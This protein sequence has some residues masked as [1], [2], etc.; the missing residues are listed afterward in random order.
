[1]AA[2]GSPKEDQGTPEGTKGSPNGPQAERKDDPRE[3]KGTPKLLQKEAWGTFGEAL[4]TPGE[5]LGRLAASGP[6]TIEGHPFFHLKNRPDLG[7]P[8][9]QNFDHFRYEFPYRFLSS[10]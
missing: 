10:F 4:G 8:R 2:M 9:G 3:A 1:M 5:T 6:K 7:N